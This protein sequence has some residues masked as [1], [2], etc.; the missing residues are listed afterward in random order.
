MNNKQ[1]NLPCFEVPD[2]GVFVSVVN[3]DESAA[4]IFVDSASLT[5]AE[6]AAI[7][8]DDSAVFLVSTAATATLS[9]D[10]GHFLGHDI[11]SLNAPLITFSAK[12]LLVACGEYRATM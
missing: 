11:S 8:F 4:L 3:F 10:A 6:S 12:P 2:I 5:L 9:F 7:V 1:K